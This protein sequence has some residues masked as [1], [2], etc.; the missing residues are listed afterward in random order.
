M[1]NEILKEIY[2]LDPSLE[3]NQKQISKLLDEMIKNKP[4]IGKNAKFQKELIKE[5]IEYSRNL[6]TN[7]NSFNNKIMQKIALILSG[8]ILAALLI[9]PNANNKPATQEIA[10]N[11]KSVSFDTSISED[12]GEAFSLEISDSETTES[13]DESMLSSKAG[14]GGGGVA[15]MDM[16]V[17][18]RIMPRPN[19][20][21]D[22]VY[23]G[24][25]VLLE[26][27]KLSVLKKDE[28]SMKVSY[29]ELISNFSLDDIDLSKFE[30]MNIANLTLSEDKEYGYQIN[31]NFE[32]GNI[33]INKNWQKWPQ[34]KAPSLNKEDVNEEE[35][36]KIA[37][38]F[39][40]DY[41]IDLS[42][43]GAPEMAENMEIIL[44]RSYIPSYYQVVFPLL[45]DGK[46]VMSSWGN[47]TGVR[48]SVDLNN[49]KVSELYGIQAQS[50]TKKS[51]AGVSDFAAV[52]KVI[53]KSGESGFSFEDPEDKENVQLQTPEF[54]WMEYSSY[55][56]NTHH[57]YLVPALSFSAIYPEEA[58]DYL[59]QQKTVVPL[60]KEML[61]KLYK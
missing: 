15:N 25:E 5:L 60:V 58:P 29:Q 13:M 51:T 6:N 7:N 27:N 45:I 44:A 42:N 20:N 30:Q 49:K 17:E 14:F 50:Y 8:G 28:Q 11:Q 38:D 39:I 23:S 1:K 56:K 31:I 33:N 37:N 36:L 22:Y 12:D 55:S 18:P 59:K 47:V 35:I 41:K 4:N 53:E 46:K 52:K 32:N 21:Y 26:N 10:M 9:L 48:V 57:L 43:Y 16:A 34:E 24:E 3:K 2:K 61:D 54:V 40:K 19:Q